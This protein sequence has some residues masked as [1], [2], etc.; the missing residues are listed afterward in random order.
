LAS[1]TEENRK[2]FREE[3]MVRLTKVGIVGAGNMGSGIAQKT[4]QEGLQ[5]V[6]V[7]IKDEFVQRGLGLIRKM[8]EE[9]VERKIFRPEQVE[10]ILELIQGTTELEALA[11]CDLVIE[12]VFEDMNVKKE[13]FGK[14]DKICKPE[15]VLA[16]NTSSFSVEELAQATGRPQNVIGLHFFYHPAKN[17]LLEVI[18]GRSSSESSVAL[19]W[20]YSRRAGKT[21]IATG[22]APGFAV[23]RF[24]VPWL[25]EA[26]RL[27]GEGVADTATIDEAAKKAFGI[28]M[29]PFLLMNVTGV[30]IA[31]HSASTLGGKLGEFYKPSETLKAQFESAKQWEIGE[32]ADE[33]KFDAVRDRLSGVVFYVAACLAGEGIATISDT[34][35]GAKIGLRWRL[36]PFEMMNRMGTGKAYGL[37]SA[38]C[39]RYDVALPANLAKLKEEGG[40]WD[41][42]YVD[43]KIDGPVAY[44]TVNRPEAMNALNPTVAVQLAEAFDA[45]DAN[46]DVKS[47]VMSGAGGKAFVAGADIG[48]FIKNIKKNTFK[49]IYDFT[50]DGHDLLK[51]IDSSKKTI[52]VKMDGL[53]LGGGL[54]LALAADCIVASEKA[55]MS[56]P[57]TGIGIY[58]GLGGMAR[59]SR[60]I[61]KE[62]AK[63]L[64]LTGKTIDGTTAHAIGLVEYV[65]SPAEIDEKV[66]A[67]AREP[68]G[69][70]TK[71]KKAQVA[72]GELPVEFEHIENLFSDEN[73]NTVLE[74]EN[75]ETDDPVVQKIAKSISYK[76]PVA[77]KMANEIMDEGFN[78]TLEEALQFELS[79]LEEIFS[80]Q[81]ALEGLSSVVER[82]RPEYKGA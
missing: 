7:D 77:V 69:A 1:R 6:L 28:G 75:L 49:N 5:V 64:V 25:N 37:V 22:D 2:H 24:F 39:E 60:Y 10:G 48:F 34:D 41:V 58:P 42:R 78:M 70:I 76:A 27:L 67:L 31:Y 11:D 15:T 17:R 38:V 80:T 63:Y 73:I 50:R 66:E 30:P 4:A 61:G 20:L 82:R 62:L 36:G 45:A 52:F 65:L 12:A 40:A 54:E 53:A 13:L 56:F 55:A 16:T 14:L 8:L 59:A 19:G 23:N 9:G 32:K 33:S 3:E 74:R 79:K 81:D 71:T 72:G 44:I 18:P 43:L 26:T 57:E 68:E 46:P 29:G 47:V 35:R 51:R 21:G